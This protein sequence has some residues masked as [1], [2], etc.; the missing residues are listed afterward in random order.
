MGRYLTS[1]VTISFSIWTMPH[2][3]GELVKQCPGY[4]EMKEYELQWL[5]KPSQINGDTKLCRM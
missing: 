3:V 5:Q 2:G 1:L 4:Y